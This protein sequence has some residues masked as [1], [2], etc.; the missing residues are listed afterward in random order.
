MKV[1]MISCSP[2]TKESSAKSLKEMADT[3]ATQDIE[4]SINI[5]PSA[6]YPYLRAFIGM[7]AMVFQPML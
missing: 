1:L 7:R 6:T 4:M 2:H 5:S 3:P